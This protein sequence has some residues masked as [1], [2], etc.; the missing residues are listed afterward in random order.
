MESSC[1]NLLEYNVFPVQIS[2]LLQGFTWST[3][4]CL[5]QNAYHCMEFRQLIL[6]IYQAFE[7]NG[8]TI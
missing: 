7:Q 3:N 2:V 8:M 1:N 4:G 6:I 5:H